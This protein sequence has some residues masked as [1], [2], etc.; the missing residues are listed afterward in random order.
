MRRV[1]RARG[2]IR[3]PLAVGGTVLL[4]LLSGGSGAVGQ[5]RIQ[6]KQGQSVQGSITKITPLEVTIAVRGKDQNL[7]LKDIR[8]ISFDR[9]RL[10]WIASAIW[11]SMASIS[12][13]PSSCWRSPGK[14]CPRS[15][16]QT[17]LRI[18]P[19]VQ[20]GMRVWPVREISPTPF[21]D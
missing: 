18:L 1:S 3:Q 20:R 15:A 21:E 6:L 8:K 16:D 19:V 7:P 10:P 5:D 12:R 17:G 13:R 9:N 4:V 2:I 14:A 11:C